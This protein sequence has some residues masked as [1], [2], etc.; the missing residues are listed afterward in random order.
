MH[1]SGQHNS[2]H[3][4]QLVFSKHALERMERRTISREMV[5]LTLTNP[6]KTFPVQE[7][8]KDFQESPKIK[9]IK[10]IH[11]RQT[12]VIA[13][14]LPDKKWL[15]ISVWIRGEEDKIPLMWQLLTLP[16]KIGWF[17]IKKMYFIFFSK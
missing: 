2:N 3:Y 10:T 12:Q 15:I 6:D 5:R 17:L 11:G 4:G 14:L 9:F 1:K 7:D 8:A 13:S 16:F